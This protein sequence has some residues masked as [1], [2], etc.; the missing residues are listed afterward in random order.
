MRIRIDWRQA[1]CKDCGGFLDAFGSCPNADPKRAAVE[2]A[3][4]Y[5]GLTV[6]A[7]TRKAAEMI[8]VA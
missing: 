2:A 5:C 1:T 6:Q 7:V 8:K 3:P 4:V